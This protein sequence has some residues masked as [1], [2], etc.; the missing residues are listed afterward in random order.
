L[1]DRLVYSEAVEGLIKYGLGGHV[2]SRLRERLGDLGLDVDRLPSTF[3]VVAWVK[4]LSVI[5]EELFPAL[6]RDE[7]FRRLARQHVDGYSRTLMG[8]ATLRVMR[9]LGPRRMMQRLVDMLAAMDNYTTG[10]V[11]ERGPSAFE[12]SLNSDLQPVAYAESV[13]ESILGAC[14]A[15][16]P[17]AKRLEGREEGAT[18]LLTWREPSGTAS[19]EPE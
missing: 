12:L 15:E 7:A 16:Q 9:L 3:P 4:C 18:Y 17:Q 11:V 19:A 8:R 10:A 6:P 5:T 13:F 14:G 2:P 1:E